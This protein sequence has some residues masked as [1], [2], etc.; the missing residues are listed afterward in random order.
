[1]TP[2]KFLPI[3]MGLI[4][5]ALLGMVVISIGILRY[6]TGMILR[7]E[8]TLNYVYWTI[9]ALSVFLTVYRFK[10]LDPAAFPW[11]Q[12]VKIGIIAGL[13][14][15][16]MYTVYII[17]LNTYID[18]ELPSKIVQYYQ[19][20]LASGSSEMSDEDIHDSMSVTTLNPAVRG[21]MYMVVCMFFGALYSLLSTLVL[22]RFH[23]F[24]T[25]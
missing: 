23:G 6:T 13:L 24:R 8:Q 19:Q 2:S 14:S 22:R 20:E 16:A 5:G 1:M 4:L 15:G 7:N 21:G 3:K 11:R 25:K 9:F 10:I 18:P 17:L 12:T